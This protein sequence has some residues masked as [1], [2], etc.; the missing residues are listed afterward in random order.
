MSAR[1]RIAQLFCA[2]LL[3]IV[4]VGVMAGPAS[5]ETTIEVTTPADGRYQPGSPTAL[6]VT[7]EAD[8]A[9]SGTISVSFEG[10]RAGSQQVEVPGGSAKDIVMIVSTPPWTS[11]GSVSF[12]ADDDEDDK[13]ER[14]SLVS[15]SGDELVALLPELATRDFPDSAELSIDLGV[16]R[17]FALDPALLDSGSEVLSTFTQVIATANDIQTLE[18]AHQ[19][20]LEAWIG[21]DGGILII[22]EESGT[23]LP[24]DLDTRSVQLTDDV[25]AFGVG[26][27]HYSDGQAISGAYDGLL[28]PTP[29]KSPDEFP[30]GGGFGGFPTTNLLAADAGVRVPAIGAIIGLL[31]IYA[32]VAGPLLWFA[33]KRSHREPLLWVALPAVALV[34]TLGVWATGRAIRDSAN[35]AHATLIADMPTLRMVS[36]QVLVTSANGG[37]AGVTMPAGWRQTSSIS[38]DSFF[39]EEGPFGGSGST[40]R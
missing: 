24:L 37:T 21:A 6:I 8:R 18:P 25:L 7:I 27:I 11:S 19:E 20:A 4:A 12:D 33:L 39:F 17:L 13:T 10:F 16:A 2:L 34:A 22:D 29:S 9:I 5:A 15:A 3:A 30:W 35:S 26:Q 32:L 40:L 28:Q 38:D 31:A 36:T 23:S 14:L 1:T